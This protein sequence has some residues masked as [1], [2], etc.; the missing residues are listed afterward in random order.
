MYERDELRAPPHGEVLAG[1]RSSAP[2]AWPACV[3]VRGVKK[4]VLIL[5][6][7]GFLGRHLAYALRE[8]GCE[9]R[10]ASRSPRRPSRPSGSAWVQADVLRLDTLSEA[11]QGCDVVVNLVHLMGQS[12]DLLLREKVAAWNIRQAAEGA[13][14]SHI[15]YLGGPRSSGRASAHLQARLATGDILRSGAVPTTEIRASMIVGS[16]SESF[17]M[18]R[19]LA[20]RLP[21]MVLPRWLHTRS[22]PIGVRDVTTALVH[23][24]MGEAPR[25]SAWFDLPGPETL[26][27]KEILLRVAAVRRRRPITVS[28]PLVSPG[29]SSHWIG[30]V[31]DADYNIAKK[32][33]AGLQSDLLFD[34]PS[35]WGRMPQHQLQPFDVAVAEAFE[36]SAAQGWAA[37]WEWL[38]G[39]LTPSPA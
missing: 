30:L 21:F 7:S 17:R 1:T 11:M 25:A 32:L 5:G 4:D 8:Q 29:L 22:S 24:C 27:A 3:G 6:A 37:Q 13:G 16:Q 19:D 36:G 10:L 34:G 20:V 35:Y 26:T 12:G 38:A 2:S 33:V 31:S 28:I 9:V 14:V 39:A 23:A 18:V 15:V